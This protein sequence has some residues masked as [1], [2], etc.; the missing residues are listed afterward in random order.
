MHWNDDMTICDWVFFIALINA[1]HRLHRTVRYIFFFFY[2]FMFLFVNYVSHFCA[3]KKKTNSIRS[4]NCT[5]IV[6]DVNDFFIWKS[7]IIKKILSS[8][9]HQKTYIIY[10][11][12]FEHWE[13]F[14]LFTHSTFHRTNMHWI[15]RRLR[16]RQLWQWWRI[17]IFCAY[18]IRNVP[19]SFQ[20]MIA[21]V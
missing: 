2:F 21:H 10:K 13:M 9:S 18:V 6:F 7:T 16:R 19:M 17:H 20:K 8:K 1:S 5:V 11:K 4:S 14:S 3:P 15:W 12:M